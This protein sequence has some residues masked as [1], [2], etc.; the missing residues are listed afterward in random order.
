MLGA[1]DERQFDFDLF[2]PRWRRVVMQHRAGNF[3]EKRRMAGP[4]INAWN[5]FGIVSVAVFDFDNYRE[6]PGSRK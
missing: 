1:D 4:S 3:T 5:R 6:I 2:V